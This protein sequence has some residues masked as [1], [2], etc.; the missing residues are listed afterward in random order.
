MEK[1]QENLK[2][3]ALK[4]SANAQENFLADSLKLDQIRMEQRKVK[5]I[6]GLLSVIEKIVKSENSGEGSYETLENC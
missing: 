1:A 3:Y 6:I 4:N 2:N 5:E